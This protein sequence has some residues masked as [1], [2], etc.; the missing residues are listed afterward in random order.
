MPIVPHKAR[1]QAAARDREISRTGAGFEAQ[2]ARVWV[3]VRQRIVRLT[4]QLIAEKGRVVSTAVNL[5]VARTVAAELQRTLQEAGYQ[6]L[7]ASALET[8]GELAKYQGLGQTR[9]LRVERTQAWSAETLDAFH[10]IK[11]RELV[12][13]SEAAIGRIEQT[14]LRGIVGA[15]DRG[16][17][18]NELLAELEVSL[19]QARTIYDTALS[20][21]SRIAVTSTATGASDEAFLYSGPI[22][23]LTRP[24]CLELVGKV[25]SR[26][27]ID[28]MDNGQLDNTLITGGGYNCRHTWL[29][30][31]P[32]DA[33]E[34][35]AGTGDYADPAYAQDAADAGAAR[36]RVKQAKR[37]AK[38][39]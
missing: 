30:V 27:D 22:D 23:G 19:P 12:Q 4:N 9:V 39:N 20:E 21:F 18:L 1:R 16:E 38:G 26:S 31:P 5:G 17:L 10:D 33:L 35:L 28:A 6:D 7:V 2:L 13:V 34:A 37:K 32:G 25:F 3:E 36:V 15:Q 11:L 29:P 24:F 8:M 14:L